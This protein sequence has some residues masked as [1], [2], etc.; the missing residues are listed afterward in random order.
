MTPPY[1]ARNNTHTDMDM[2]HAYVLLC[3][4]LYRAHTHNERSQLWKRLNCTR[5]FTFCIQLWNAVRCICASATKEV[6][7]SVVILWKFCLRPK[8]ND[9]FISCVLS[10]LLHLYLSTSSCIKCWPSTQRMHTNTIKVWILK[11]AP[12]R[13]TINNVWLCLA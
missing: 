2:V 5:A 1:I 9:F 11:R 10:T 8:T 13:K 6:H 4:C 3:L 12:L 7:S